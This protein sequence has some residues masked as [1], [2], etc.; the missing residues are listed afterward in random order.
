MSPTKMFSRL[1]EDQKKVHTVLKARVPGFD[2]R[3]PPRLDPI[4]LVSVVALI[5]DS[6]AKEDWSETRSLLDLLPAYAKT[7]AMPRHAGHERHL[8][9]LANAVD[10]GS[11]RQAE[12]HLTRLGRIIRI[13]AADDVLEDGADV[14]IMRTRHGWYD[15]HVSGRIAEGSNG[16][17]VETADGERYE[18]EHRRDVTRG[19]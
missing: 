11:R 19:R 1:S 16:S 4:E 13:V 17:I 18:I 12:I 9:N 5:G 6:V 10:N 7:L 3:N 8:A 2:A 15:G 14:R